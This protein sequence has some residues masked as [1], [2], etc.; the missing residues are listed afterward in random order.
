MKKLLIL[1]FMFLAVRCMAAYILLFDW[2]NPY[3]TKPESVIQNLDGTNSKSISSF[4]DN[5][6][7]TVRLSEWANGEF[8]RFLDIYLN[9][10][11]PLDGELGI[12][13]Y[14]NDLPP[15]GTGAYLDSLIDSN[16]IKMELL[17]ITF[18]ED[19]NPI[20][21]HPFAEAESTVRELREHM[22]EVPQ[23]FP[24][25]PEWWPE[26]FIYTVPVPEPS[27]TVLTMLGICAIL[28][29]RRNG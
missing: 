20:S 23:L 7:N 15:V 24:I 18:D 12:E 28:M 13:A 2:D 19:W 1:L 4:S 25:E 6:F 3:G 14:P 17:F 29:R 22:Y 27:I 11:G 10:D 9:T 26:T 16:T 5:D 21:Y 8:V